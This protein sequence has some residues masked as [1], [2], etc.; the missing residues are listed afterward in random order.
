MVFRSFGRGGAHR[1]AK[2]GFL[3]DEVF[4]HL[5]ESGSIEELASSLGEIAFLFLDMVLKQFLKHGAA[6]RPLL[7]LGLPRRRQVSKQA[8]YDVVLDRSFERLGLALLR[9]FEWPVEDLFLCAAMY[10]QFGFEL[11]EEFPPFLAALASKNG[12]E[13]ALTSSWSAFSA[14]KIVITISR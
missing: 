1:Y 10:S 11:L 14:S 2:L 12:F 13:Q 7:R 9:L 3:G 4:A 6:S 5:I 8:I